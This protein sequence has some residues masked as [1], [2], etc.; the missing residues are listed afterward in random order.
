MFAAAQARA[1]RTLASHAFRQEREA[2]DPTMV[3]YIPVLSQINAAGFL[4]TESQAGRRSQGRLAAGRIDSGQPYE[5]WE[6]AYV[7][8]FMTATQGERFLQMINIVTDKVAQRV[9]V[10]EAPRETHGVT[11][12][13]RRWDL[14]LTVTFVRHGTEWQEPTITTH[15]SWARPLLSEARKNP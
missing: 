1:L 14:P 2:E 9:P 10:L 3:Q 12:W 8:G 5:M 6:R 4:T 13:E 11:H 7:C 15:Q